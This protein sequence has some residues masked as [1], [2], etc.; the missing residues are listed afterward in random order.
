MPAADLLAK[1]AK[2]NETEIRDWLEGNICPGTVYHNIVRAVQIASN[3][4]KA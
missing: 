4:T 2:L 1:N 3:S